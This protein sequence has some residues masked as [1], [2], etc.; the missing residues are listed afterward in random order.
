M[1]LG[2]PLGCFFLGFQRLRQGKQVTTDSK[3]KN[4]SKYSQLFTYMHKKN[5]SHPGQFGSMVEWRPAH[6]RSQVQLFVKGIT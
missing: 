5:M 1:T 6:Q 2:I 4:T 3:R